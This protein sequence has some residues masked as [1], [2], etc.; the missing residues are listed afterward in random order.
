MKAITKTQLRER[1]GEETRKSAFIS[2]A[3]AELK[4]QLATAR[5]LIE[6]QTQLIQQK[7]ETILNLNTE[8]GQ[9][10]KRC[11]SLQVVVDRQLQFNRS[12][13]RYLSQFE[14]ISDLESK[15]ISK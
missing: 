13:V 6:V 7:R 11:E 9:L 14:E 10:T 12:S 4:E 1:L 2:Q 5:S 8:V 3:Y 15:I